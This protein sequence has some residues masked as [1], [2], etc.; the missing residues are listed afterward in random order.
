MC[1]MES[2]DFLSAFLGERSRGGGSSVTC[3]LWS[4]AHM[5]HTGEQQKPGETPRPFEG[6]PTVANVSPAAMYVFLVLP[7]RLW[8]AIRQSSGFRHGM[9]FVA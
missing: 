6:G 1:S 5:T 8:A 2:Q 3:S 4:M 7:Q 9:G